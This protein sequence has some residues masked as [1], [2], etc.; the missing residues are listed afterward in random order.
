MSDPTPAPAAEKPAP[1]WQAVNA[2]ERRVLGVLAEKAKTTPDAYPMS[3]NA[4]VT[5]SNQKSNRFPLMQLEA[6][7]VEEALDKL[8]QMGAV[9]MIEG[10]GR[11]VK[12]RH[13]LYEW[14]GVDKVEIAVMTELLLR[15]AQTEGELR[16]R[17]ARMEPI[18]DLAA[19]RTILD[20]LRAKKLVVSLTPE[21]RGHVVSHNLYKDRELESVRA[22]FQGRAVPEEEDEGSLPLAAPRPAAHAATQPR[23]AASDETR[24]EL[25][26]LR[27]L[28]SSLRQEV[29]DL[30][31]RQARTENEL[32]RLRE[33][34]GG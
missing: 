21:G 17:A 34:L 16:G 4:I 30:S 23:P 15:G 26:E 31:A 2:T 12:Y 24:R 5:G 6:D 11:V 22:Q 33:S 25:G 1:R 10:Y 19:L 18:A 32:Q 9:A 8:R 3:L 20:S 27:I 14:L 7:A 28:V 29:E 13:L